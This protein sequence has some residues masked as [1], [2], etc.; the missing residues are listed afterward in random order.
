MENTPQSFGEYLKSYFK[1][2]GQL[3]KNPLALLPTILITGVW[4]LLG[5]LKKGMN[6]SPVMAVLNFLT[7]AQEES[8]AESSA[9]SVA[10]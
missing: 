10:L 3:L 2:Y 5:F 1:N 8:S 7:F 9:P 6:E 4:I